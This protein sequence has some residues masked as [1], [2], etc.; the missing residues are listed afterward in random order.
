MSEDCHSSDN[1]VPT[2]EVQIK[3]PLNLADIMA[4]VLAMPPGTIAHA[5]YTSTDDGPGAFRLD[6]INGSVRIVG[7]N[8]PET[9]VLHKG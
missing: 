9:G 6:A 1:A 5:T 7:Y 4:M 8:L 2:T 3:Q